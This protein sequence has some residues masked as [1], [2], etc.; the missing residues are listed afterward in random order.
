[1]FIINLGLK[2]SENHFQG[3]DLP[4]GA[5]ICI[6]RALNELHAA[7]LGNFSYLKVLE[8][9]TEKTLVVCFTGLFL[10]C[11][12]N[13]ITNLANA[14][15][16]DCIAVFDVD[17]GQGHLIGKYAGDWGEFNAKYFLVG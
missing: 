2:T 5:D 12:A 11:R 13:D 8:S 9:N 1:M 16:Q 10:N 6:A 3:G 4:L 14:L 15:Q 7:N 17:K